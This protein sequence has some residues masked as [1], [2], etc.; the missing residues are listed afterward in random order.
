MN[1]RVVWMH[2]TAQARGMRVILAADHLGGREAD[3]GRALATGE[4]AVAHRLVDRLGLG[5]GGGKQA[6]QRGHRLFSGARP[7]T[8]KIHPPSTRMPRHLATLS[9]GGPCFLSWPCGLR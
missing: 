9:R 8:R 5:V 2:S 1:Q 6:I 7:V 3:D 4:N